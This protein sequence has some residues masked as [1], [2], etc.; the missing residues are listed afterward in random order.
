MAEEIPLF[1]LNHVLLPGMPL[2]LHIFEPRYRQLLSDITGPAGTKSFGVV[3]LRT[4]TEVRTSP[5]NPEGAPDVADIGT[6]A[7]ILEDTVRPDGSS[8]VLSVGSKRFRIESLL[9]E[10]TPYLRGRVS[11][12]DEPNGELNSEAELAARQLLE[13]Y[14]AILLRLA[15]RA[16][17]SELPTDPT[18]LSY[19]I[20]ARLPL[21]PG[22]RQALLA[23]ATTAVRLERIGQFLRRELRLLQH[24]RSIAVSPTILRLSASLN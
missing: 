24:T 9:T 5:A 7:E 6:L 16:T 10:P 3:V 11:F 15:G 19:Q 14:D 13:R 18:L 17:G 2:P 8:D 12:L 21:A 4:G 23:A 22:E 20:A 1:P